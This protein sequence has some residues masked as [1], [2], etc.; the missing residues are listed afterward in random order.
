MSGDGLVPYLYTF[1][2]ELN[3]S[4]GSINSGSMRWFFEKDAAGKTQEALFIEHVEIAASLLVQRISVRRRICHWTYLPGSQFHR[5]TWPVTDIWKFSET[6]P[7]SDQG[8]MILTLLCSDEVVY[9][10][11]NILKSHQGQARQ[12][13]QSMPRLRYSAAMWAKNG[14]RNIEAAGS[15]LD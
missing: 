2:L 4:C 7:L 5:N 15:D 12:N 6:F 11:R 14:S 9:A 3:V 13:G 10:G 1:T 8:I